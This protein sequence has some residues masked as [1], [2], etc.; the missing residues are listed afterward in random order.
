MF[1]IAL[2]PKG[3]MH[4]QDLQIALFN[5]I[6]SRQKKEELIIRIEDIDIK[7]VKENDAKTVGLL[8]LFGI[9]YK[10]VLYQSKNLKF[11][12]AMALDLLHRKKAFNCFCP[13]EILEKQEIYDGTCE[14]LPAELVIDNP[15]PFSVRIKKPTSS[16]DFNDHI[17]GEIKIEQIDSFM[18]LKSNKTPT[19]DFAHGVD[20]MLNNISFVIQCDTCLKNTAKQIHIRKSLRY[21]KEIQYAHLPCIQNGKNISITQL[22]KNGYLPQAIVNYVILLT[23]KTPKNFLP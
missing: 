23:S 6:L 19:Y 12:S 17:K 18:I 3:D 4:I 15:N 5:Y 8:E 2:S 20:D 11:Y 14:N 13:S 1:R 16:I 21:D 10:E 9:T 22:L 7:D